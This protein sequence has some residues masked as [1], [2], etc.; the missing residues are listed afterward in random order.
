MDELRESDRVRR[1]INAVLRGKDPLLLIQVSSP[2]QAT[3]PTSGSTGISSKTEA[4]ASTAAT[5]GSI[6]G[7]R[8]KCCGRTAQLFD[9]LLCGICVVGMWRAVVTPAVHVD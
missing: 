4:T 3:R 5:T 9:G 2:S 6:K 8:C 7:G 1:I